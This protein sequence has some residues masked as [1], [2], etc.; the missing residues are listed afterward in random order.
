M[1]TRVEQ[2]VLIL[3]AGINGCAV[4]RDLVLNGLPVVI[5]DSADIASGASSRSSRLIHGGLR[6]LEYGDFQLVRES[7]DERRRLLRLAPH[8]VK[9]LRL[10]IPVENRFG[11]FLQSVL[12]LLRLS[13]LLDFDTRTSRGLWLVRLGLWLYDL[14]AKDASCPGHEVHHRD[15]SHV[16]TVTDRFRWLCSYTD[17]QVTMTE[18]FVIDLLRDTERVATTNSTEFRVLTYYEARTVGDQVELVPTN[19]DSDRSDSIGL[20]PSMIINATGSWGDRTLKQLRIASRQLFGG[21]KGSHLFTRHSKLR[22][23]IGDD[24]IYAEAADGR[25]VFILPFH[26]GVLIGTT[27]VVYH[28][29]PSLAVADDDEVGYLIRMVNEVVPSIH[30]GR[31]DILSSYSG[32]RPLPF[33]ERNSAAAIPRG[34]WL[35]MNDS[36]TIPIMTLIGG[37]LT[38]CRALAEEVT[39][40]V[41]QH[42]GAY[43]RTSTTERQLPGAESF[44]DNEADA[45]QALSGKFNLPSEVVSKL[46]MLFGT[47]AE[48]VLSTIE[49]E[50]RETLD[51]TSIPVGVVDWIIQNEWVATLSDIVERRLVLIFGSVTRRCLEQ[52][53]GRLVKLGRLQEA[54]MKTEIENCVEKLHVIYSCKVS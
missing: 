4:A 13:N 3:G 26:D 8:F 1:S 21:T 15:E 54:Q 11:G 47:M 27:D 7:L 25:L 2:P 33:V 14:F 37:K 34:H 42:V 32:V 16:P 41:L 18:R 51:G 24:G 9:P 28:D 46:W 48:T 53:A 52:I 45:I 44:P 10:Y 50:H 19:P 35:E 38:T 29:D 40:R 31:D 49:D 43:R 22:Q 5:V 6:Y 30:L 39:D 12:R 23:S 36:S 20:Q 17:A